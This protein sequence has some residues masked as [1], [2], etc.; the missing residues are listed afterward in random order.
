MSYGAEEAALEMLR[1]TCEHRTGLSLLQGP[2]LSGKSTIIR[3]F[4]E[5]APD[6]CALA[7]IDGKGLNS[8]GLLH[9]VLT[10]FGYDLETNSANELL[11]L[12]RV[13]AM[14]RAA[15]HSPPML[16]IENAHELNPSALRTLCELADLRV[17]GNSAVKMVLVSARTLASIMSTRAM[18]SIA[19]R[20]LHDFHLR[21][22][23]PGEA[24]H[25]L[26]TKLRSAGCIDPE[27]VFPIE[28]CK[29][30]WGA[31]EGW[32][33]II[34]R[35]AVLALAQ[36]DELPVSV[37]A[38]ERPNLPRGTWDEVPDSSL[39]DGFLPARAPQLIVTNDGTVLHDMKMQK[40]RILIGRSKHNDISIESRF[41][42]RHQALLA[43][44]GSVTILM[45]L[46]STNGTFVNSRRISNHVLLHNDIVTIG[47][48]RIKFHDPD[49]TSRGSLDGAEFTD[50]A[51]MK[52]LDDM[53]K[54]LAKKN[55][56]LVVPES[57][58]LPTI[59]T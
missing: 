13:F 5:T 36:A 15:S 28:V 4:V 53:R 7:M 6:D 33:G 9:A 30:L 45:D 3:A 57:E 27:G 32:P 20:V 48:H 34:E 16:I 19:K 23:T 29:E 50:T 40:S 1:S 43:R 31:S 52:T 22:M 17:R 54:L 59:L 39:T 42:S 10:H 25:Y 18:E 21:P 41:I 35:I 11:G 14:Q 55:A 51:I 37:S 44:N 2:P 58:D 56:S 46:N 12:V 8:T 49:A 38:V 47:H 26:H 24:V